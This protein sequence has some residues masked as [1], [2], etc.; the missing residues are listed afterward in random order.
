MITIGIKGTVS[1]FL[2]PRNYK[3]HKGLPHDH[4]HK[5]LPHDHFVLLYL[6]DF[7]MRWNVVFC[8]HLPYSCCWVYA[9]F[10]TIR[11]WLRLGYFWMGGC[12]YADR[13]VRVCAVVQV[14][15]FYFFASVGLEVHLIW[16]EKCFVYF[17]LKCMFGMWFRSG[18]QLA[19]TVQFHRLTTCCKWSV[20]VYSSMLWLMR[21]VLAMVQWFLAYSFGF[22]IQ[23]PSSGL[24]SPAAFHHC[25]KFYWTLSYQFCFLCICDESSILEE[26]TC[27]YAGLGPAIA[28]SWVRRLI[29]DHKINGGI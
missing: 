29:R 13:G 24:L 16:L 11:C 2:K 3:V 22:L 15:P 23:S 1:F 19:E 9:G 20:H 4:I 21:I 10:H 28:R 17:F 25:G 12:G 26:S 7:V 6:I 5:S 27:K 8:T 18:F 14:R